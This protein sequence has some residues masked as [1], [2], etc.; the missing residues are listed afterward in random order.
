MTVQAWLAPEAPDLVWFHGADH[1]KFLNDLI[2][3]EIGSMSPG[4]VRRSFLLAPQGKLDHILWVVKREDKVGLITDPGRGD[5]LAAALRRYRIRVDVEIES[6]PDP[7]WLVV[8]G[9]SSQELNGIDI[10]WSVTR[11]SL[12]VGHRPDVP[13]GNADRYEMLRIEEGEP[14][15]GTDVDDT[16]IP[17]ESGLVSESVDFSKGCFLGQEL[18][19]RIESRGSNVPRRLR[20]LKLNGEVEPGAVI[21]S[22]GKEVGRLTSSSGNLGMGLVKRQ[23]E[24]GD[25]VAVGD[26]QATVVEITSKSQT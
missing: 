9:G 11:R 7:V 17:E 19:A 1:V 2:S 3:Q 12:L 5:A 13:S 21:V 20:W 6:E 16:T 23:V 14:A 26:G 10:S 8:G 25:L 24:P 15:W 22:D 4:E 18:V